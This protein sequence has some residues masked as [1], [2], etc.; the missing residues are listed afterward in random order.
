MNGPL[1]NPLTHERSSGKING[2]EIKQFRFISLYGRIEVIR[3]YEII[4]YKNAGEESLGVN[5]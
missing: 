3:V 4:E 5:L 2:R 1:V